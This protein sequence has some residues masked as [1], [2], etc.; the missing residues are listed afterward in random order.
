[1]GRSL[2]QNFERNG[3][4]VVG[5]DPNPKLDNS[6]FKDK[7]IQAFNVLDDLVSALDTPRCILMMVPAGKPV[8]VA[9]LS[10]KP[11]LGKG[12]ILI[13]GGNSYFLDTERR[14]RNLNEDGIRFIGSI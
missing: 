6:P 11:F 13:D 1:M 9:I 2:A 7:K 10:V 12:D 4:A 8:D 5:Y 3:Y 14:I